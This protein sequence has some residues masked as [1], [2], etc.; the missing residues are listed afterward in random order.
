MT[1]SVV[2]KDFGRRRVFGAKESVEGGMADRLETIEEVRATR[3]LVSVE[4]TLEILGH[5]QHYEARLLPL[6]NDQTLAIIRNITDRKRAET[7][8]LHTS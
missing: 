2:K 3:R 4:Y 8:R 6:V 7:E 1:K 5:E